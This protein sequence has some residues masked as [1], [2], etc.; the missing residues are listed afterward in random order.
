MMGV[1]CLGNVEQSTCV[2][3]KGYFVFSKTLL[4]HLL[5]DS[6]RPSCLFFSPFLFSFFLSFSPSEYNLLCIVGGTA[7]VHY[8]FQKLIFPIG[9]QLPFHT[10]SQ[11]EQK[12][13]KET[14]N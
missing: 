7:E 4:S 14:D 5:W 8:T 10:L 3:V 11:W 1:G 9:Q 6:Y 13:A 2:D 12:T